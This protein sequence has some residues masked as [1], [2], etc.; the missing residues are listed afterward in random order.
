LFWTRHRREARRQ[1]VLDEL[2]ALGPDERRGRL[3]QAVVAGDVRADEV[4]SALRLVGRLDALRVMTV[5]P[6]GRLPGGIAP[7][8][9]RH[10]ARVDSGPD[11][12]RESAMASQPIHDGQAGQADR[13]GEAVADEDPAEAA[14]RLRRSRVASSAR[15]GRRSSRRRRRPVTAA[16]LPSEGEIE[17]VPEAPENWPSIEW[18]RP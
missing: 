5:P 7:I 10:L 4:D 17:I 11:A 14:E 8:T 1:Q 13:A 2:L 6:S 16:D 12:A 3:D 18:L 9:E 15:S